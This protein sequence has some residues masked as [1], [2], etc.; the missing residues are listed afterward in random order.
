MNNLQVIVKQKNKFDGKRV[1]EF[2]E[3]DSKLC[4]SLSVYNR[5]FFNVLQGQERPSE[6]DADQETTRATWDATSQYLYSVL[7]FTTSGLAFSVVRRLEGKTPAE[8]AE[9]GQQA[10]AALREKF[11][12]CSRAEHISMTSTRMRPGQEPDDY[13]YHMNSCRDRLNVCDSPE[14]PT[15]RQYEDI[16]LQALPSEY[17]RIRQAHLE[18]RDF[19]LAGIRRMITAIYVD[20]LSRSESSKDIAGCGAAMQAV[21]RDHTNVLCHY[22]DQFGHFKKK[23]PLPIKHQKQQWQQPVRHH[24]QQ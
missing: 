13:L 8:G 5:I 7:F 6:F 20:N 24:Q 12:G 16:I 4:A 1:D 22:C 11:N 23:C 3:W 10:W 9:H 14:G 2:L 19:G 15:D 21:D 17:D 18:R